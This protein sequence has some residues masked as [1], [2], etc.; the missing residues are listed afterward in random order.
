[1][2]ASREDREVL[3]A[4]LRAGA[5]GVA[6][7]QIRSP[8]LVAA[9]RAVAAGRPLDPRADGS[10]F[11]GREGAASLPEPIVAALILQ[12]HRVLGGVVEINTAAW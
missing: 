3:Q 9:V 6:L 7:K 2:L 1:M 5:A 8:A 10:G 11:L 12:E 4:S